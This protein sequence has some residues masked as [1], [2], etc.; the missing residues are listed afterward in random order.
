MFLSKEA[1]VVRLQMEQRRTERSRRPFVLMLLESETLFKPSHQPD[2]CRQVLSVLS[3][4]LRETDV[5][6]WYENG[7]SIGIIF[8]EIG[9][10]YD[11]ALG[12]QLVIKVRR[13]LAE[14]LNGDQITEIKFTFFVFPQDWDKESP[15]RLAATLYPANHGRVSHLT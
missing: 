9:S 5:K 4:S 7:S 10:T 6:G 3:S 14:K 12:S 1:F 11:K 2:A 15:S 13:L 8:T